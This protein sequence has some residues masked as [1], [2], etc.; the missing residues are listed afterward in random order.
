MHF[1]ASVALCRCRP[2][3]GLISHPRSPIISLKGWT[4]IYFDVSSCSLVEFFPS[5]WRDIQGTLLVAWLTSSTLTMETV[6]SP[7][8]SVGFYQT[9]RRYIRED[10]TFIATAWSIKR[11]KGFINSSRPLLWAQMYKTCCSLTLQATWG[12]K[13]APLPRMSH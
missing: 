8:T 2:S 4:V 9:T 10:S 1:Y 12:N 5:F 11:W 6:P 3:A 13:I 7:E